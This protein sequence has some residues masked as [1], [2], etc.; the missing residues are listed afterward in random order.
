M[1][2]R[3]RLWRSKDQLEG[4]SGDVTLIRRRPPRPLSST[5][6]SYRDSQV[7]LSPL[8]PPPLTGKP[9]RRASW[10]SK[11]LTRVDGRRGGAWPSDEAAG[12][13]PRCIQSQSSVHLN[14]PVGGASDTCSSAQAHSVMSRCLRTLTH[15]F[16]WRKRE[17]SPQF[18][19]NRITPANGVR[20]P[21]D[22]LPNPI[23]SILLMI[24]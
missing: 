22:R 9:S 20:Q 7:S 14:R 5:Y 2:N 11:S 24:F 10:F 12:H 16:N 23:F 15:R 3:Q 17:N 4:S 18:N 6:R 19:S 8:T 13:V 21:V 1:T